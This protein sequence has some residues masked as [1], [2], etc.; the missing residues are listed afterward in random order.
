VFVSA[1]NRLIIAPSE[2]LGHS[3]VDSTAVMIVSTQG[4]SE[5]ET[6]GQMRLVVYSRGVLHE[7]VLALASLL[8]T[9]EVFFHRLVAEVVRGLLDRPADSYLHHGLPL[10]A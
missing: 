4:G 8:L 6:R 3:E 1:A 5:V 9:Q 2:W 10:G 7:L